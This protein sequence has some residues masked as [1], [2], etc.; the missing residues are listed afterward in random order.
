MF[1]LFLKES[2]NRKTTWISKNNDNSLKDYD[3]Q[4]KSYIK[5]NFFNP[6]YEINYK[7]EGEYHYF[8][9]VI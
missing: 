4:I 6:E 5:G 7:E 2:I 9:Q 1:C 8:I 3:L